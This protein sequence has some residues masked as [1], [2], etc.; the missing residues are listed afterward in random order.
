[1]K[2]SLHFNLD[3]FTRSQEAT[4]RNIPNEPD[5]TQLANI[6]SLVNNLLEP[7][8]CIV[9]KPM[10]ITSGLR[11]PLLNN[12]VRGNS[13]SQHV[14]GQAVDF[15]FNGMSVLDGCNAILASGL[16]FDQLIYEGTWIHLSYAEGK[17]RNEVLTATF[18]NGEAMY[19]KGL[20]K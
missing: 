11:T 1:M 12:A 13:K 5:T 2:L 16:E 19:S 7:L 17:N 3:E 15:V 20:P 4:R 14:K 10:Q 9:N 6:Q 8:R 18:R